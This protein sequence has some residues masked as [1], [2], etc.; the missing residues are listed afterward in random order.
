M[1]RFTAT[2]K[3]EESR[4]APLTTEMQPS[5]NRLGS[6]REREDDTLRLSDVV[7]P[8]TGRSSEKLRNAFSS[9]TFRVAFKRCA[10]RCYWSRCSQ[11]SH[12]VSVAAPEGGTSV[13]LMFFRVC[14]VFSAIGRGGRRGS[15]G[16]LDQHWRELHSD[17]RAVPG[18]PARRFPHDRLCGCV[19][20]RDADLRYLRRHR[21]RHACHRRCCERLPRQFVQF[22]SNFT[23]CAHP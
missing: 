7:H 1:H 12:W 8:A 11:R 14:S 22:P 10:R 5:S 18:F 16:A 3:R 17:L 20:R 19:P 2:E 4:W 6:R 9:V 21:R 23:T 13:L 15:H